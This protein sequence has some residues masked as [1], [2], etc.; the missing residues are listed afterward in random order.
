MENI[1]NKLN[2]TSEIVGS[3]IVGRD[4]LVIASNVPEGVNAEL[5]GAM[6]AG[7]FT[8]AE[9]SMEEL[10]QGEVQTVMIEG[11]KGKVILCDA[12][13]I[14]VVLLDEVTNLGLVR[15]EVKEAVNKLKEL[16]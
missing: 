11:E 9:S 14:L 13:A 2:Q 12:G 16:L 6:V 1:L 8:S 15:L 7:V 5:I 4:G 3:L 10:R